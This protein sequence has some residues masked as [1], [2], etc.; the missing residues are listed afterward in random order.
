[1]IKINY[2]EPEENENVE[3]IARHNIIISDKFKKIDYLEMCCI[4]WLKLDI[5]R[6]YQ[7][8]EQLFRNLNLDSYVIAHP[9][10]KIPD[11]IELNYPNGKI[12]NEILTF[13][14]K[15][16]NKTK[17]ESM[18]ELLSIHS[19]Y[20][21]NFKCLKKTGCLMLKNNN[22][23]VVKNLPDE[24]QINEIKKVLDCKL[25]LEFTVFDSLKSIDLIIE[26][27]TN[28]YGKKPEKIICGES[29][30][31]KVYGLTI[32]GKII[33]P[34]GWIE[35]NNEIISTSNNKIEIELIDFRKVKIERNNNL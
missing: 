28:E 3:D 16:L 1:M 2:R 31:N 18:N 34:I 21:E 14:V 33:S 29:N 26:N 27:L 15:I 12:S 17:E 7:D 8:L 19:S 30:S 32:D 4:S 20:D 23:E 11:N 6:D 24:P 13:T 9:I 10:Q 35:K 25:K 5:E 22:S